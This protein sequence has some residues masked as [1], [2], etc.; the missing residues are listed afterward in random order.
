MSRSYETGILRRCRI[1]WNNRKVSAEALIASQIALHTA[2]SGESPPNR[3][4]PASRIELGTTRSAKARSPLC[5]LGSTPL[6]RQTRQ[7]STSRPTMYQ[8]RSPTSQNPKNLK[9]RLTH[10]CPLRAANS[11]GTTTG[12]AGRLMPC[13][14]STASD[15]GTMNHVLPSLPSRSKTPTWCD[16]GAHGAHVIRNIATL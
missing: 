9:L 4:T 14:K 8:H 2:S 10:G 13:A 15:P 1:T 16:P 7:S 11:I 6:W 12:T 5:F 3:N